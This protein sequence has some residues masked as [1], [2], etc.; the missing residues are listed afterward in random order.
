MDRFKEDLLR[1]KTVSVWGAGY[2]GYTKLLRLQARGFQALV[3]DLTGTGFSAKIKRGA[4]PDAEQVHSWSQSG[5]VPS[6]DASRI[7]VAP[8]ASLLA[9]RVHFFAAP[10]ADRRG[11]SLLDGFLKTLA[12][13]RRQVKDS[14]VVFLSVGA[15]GELE[16]RFLAPARRLGLGCGVAT[17]FRSDWTVEEYLRPGRKRVLAADGPESLRRARCLY[18][19]LGMP[20]EELSSIKEAEIYENAKNGLQ[21]LAGTF[22]NQL[23]FAYPS[24]DIR[25]MARLLP[26]DVELSESHLGIGSGGLKTSFA[27]KNLLE[28]SPAADHLSLLRDVQESDF[29]SVLLYGELAKR[30]GCRSAVILGLSARGNQKSVELS[31]SVILAEHLHKMGVRV[32]VDDPF[33]DPP[34][35]K[36]ILPFARHADVLRQ[37]VRAD[38]LFVMADH[39]R[40]QYL[41]QADIERLGISRVPLVVDSAGLLRGLRFPA[42][43]LYHAVGDGNLGRI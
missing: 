16:R 33:Y 26:E 21:Y 8:A 22:L 41:S 18:S 12:A 9:S 37:G 30:R 25:R 35:L 1:D 6:I 20:H 19:L 17:A 42:G 24:T 31:P 14:L 7:R 32:A 15:P 11:R 43:T 34:A 29:A 40:Y 4:Y 39:S 23:A 10:L 36:A 28:G 3:Q 27:A 2:L 13:R 38:A 5:R